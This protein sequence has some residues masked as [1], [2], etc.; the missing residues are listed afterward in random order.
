M[1]L[2]PET[3]SEKDLEEKLLEQKRRQSKYGDQRTHDDE[4][5]NE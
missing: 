5:N 1:G 4:D 2:D 3:D